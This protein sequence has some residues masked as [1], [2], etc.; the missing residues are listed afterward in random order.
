MSILAL[1][2][3]LFLPKPQ[4]QE[5]AVDGERML[6]AKQTNINRRNQP[7]AESEV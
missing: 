2:A 1:I 3:A 6:M 4:R 5:H 7:V